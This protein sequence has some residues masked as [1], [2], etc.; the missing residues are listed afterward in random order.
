MGELARVYVAGHLGLVGSALVRRL[1]R[2]PLDA[3][4][5]RTRAELDL[6]DR[7]AVEQ[8]F[9]AEKPTQVFLAAARVGGIQANL[10]YPA[11]FI[12][13]NLLIETHVI[14]AAFRHGVEKLLFLGS[15]CIY[16]RAAPQPIRE[17][18]L[19]SGP[20]E[21]TN[22]A[23][24]LAKI[25]GIELC[26]AYRVQ[27]GFDAI[28]AMPT[29]L[30]GPWDDFDPGNAHVVPALMR[31]FAEA[32]AAGAQE[33]IVWGTGTPR[34][35]FLHVDDLAD[36]L[37]F[38]MR[39]YSDSAPINIGCGSDLSIAELAELIARVVGFTGRIKFDPSKPDGTPRKLLDVSRM[40]DLG[41]TARIPLETG[42]NETWHW[43]HSQGGA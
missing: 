25:A 21:I 3:L 32:R 26:R 9:A 38:L 6:T 42:L 13:Q 14:D 22:Q 43:Y 10:T 1:A 30:Y 41:W 27:H 4:L 8:F 34:R 12:R 19:L 40:R 7:H 15:S 36:A 23:Y 33:V 35:E 29:N 28:S 5:T 11:D 37:V 39:H 31:R 20:L 18:A 2:E 16:P 17:E 24:A